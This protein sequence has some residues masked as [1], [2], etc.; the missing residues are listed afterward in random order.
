MGFFQTL[1]KPVTK[2]ISKIAGDR[3]LSDPLK[4]LPGGGL[5]KTGGNLI[6]T[7][8]SIFVKPISKLGGGL[9]SFVS[10]AGKGVSNVPGLSAI[11]SPLQNIPGNPLNPG[12]FLDGILP[13]GQTLLIIGALGVGGLIVFSKL[14]K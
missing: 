3:D 10:T 7:G 14:T 2:S 9:S 6:K 8:G 11:T 1:T 12:G 13:D 4:G 5:I